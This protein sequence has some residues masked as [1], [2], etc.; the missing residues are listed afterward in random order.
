MANIQY[1]PYAQQV[2]AIQRQRKLAD[3]LQQQG[4]EPLEQQTAGEFVVPISPWQSLAKIIQAGAG[5]YMERKAAKS[6]AAL[7]KQ[8]QEE[9]RQSVQ[10]LITA[11]EPQKAYTSTPVMEQSSDED[12]TEMAPK[13]QFNDITGQYE[14]V[15]DWKETFKPG[16]SRNEALARILQMQ[17]SE[18]P[19]IAQMAP[20]LTALLPK[21]T[22]GA[23]L[24]NKLDMEK[25][26]PE[27]RQMVLQ[28]GDMRYAEFAPEKLTPYQEAELDWKQKD[29]EV[30]RLEA[31]VDNA[32]SD[33]QLK[34]SQAQLE[35]A[36][37]SR[38]QSRKEFEYNYP[39]LAG[40]YTP[41][42][43]AG[44]APPA[45]MTTPAGQPP[46]QPPVQSVSKPLSRQDQMAYNAKIEPLNDAAVKLNSYR[47]AL[48]EV[49]RGG[50]L[51]GA[52][53]G[54][55]DTAYANAMSAVR[56]LQ[57][58][59][60]YNPGEAGLLE[61]AL[62]DARTLMNTADPTSRKRIQAQLD[63][64]FKNLNA[65]KGV[66][67]QQ[68]QQAPTPLTTVGGVSATSAESE[69]ARLRSKLFPQSGQ[70]R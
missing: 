6:E 40:G 50:S 47:Q 44:N 23:D 22:S 25:L 61:K 16:L 27:S 59:G 48:D 65:K 19:Y 63:E 55:L 45:G 42:P 18:N 46:A 36:R 10:D 64:Q 5:S 34:N 32:R 38:D 49:S 24:F 43:P 52:G 17:T 15:L 51:A 37:Q 58:T 56:I 28:T 12:R 35:L 14:P 21:E 67:D 11:M 66:I 53:A 33:A 54:R 13:T 20:A 3:L 2:A 9:S 8:A 39:N 62:G 70:P 30:R 29:A 7:K 60:V 1:L 4:M 26:T 69:K 68:F 57:N 41:A 31:Q